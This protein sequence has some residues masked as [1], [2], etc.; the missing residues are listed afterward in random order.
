M[1][2]TSYEI[3]GYTFEIIIE[4]ENGSFFGTWRRECGHKGGSGKACSLKEDA[5]HFAKTNASAHHYTNQKNEILPEIEKL[6]KEHIDLV[7][8]F[9]LISDTLETLQHQFDTL[10]QKV[11]QQK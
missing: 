8:K 5:V 11:P 10:I 3:E 2:T 4:K 6:P 7:S 9:K 1:T